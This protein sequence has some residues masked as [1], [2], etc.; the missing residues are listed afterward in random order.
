MTAE[1]YTALDAGHI[2]G[3]GENTFTFTMPDYPVSVDVEF[4]DIPTIY[5]TYDFQT[6]AMDTNNITEN[7]DATI[8]LDNGGVMTGEYTGDK[9]VSGKKMTLN[10]AFSITGN[11]VTSWVLSKNSSEDKAGLKLGR[12]TS[13]NAT[14]TINGLKVGDW[15]VIEGSEDKLG[16]VGNNNYVC[17]AGTTTTITNSSILK[18]STIYLVKEG[19]T[20]PVSI[21]LYNGVSGKSGD[22]FIYSIK[23][24]KDDNVPAPTISVDGGKVEI[25]GS[26]LKGNP[27]TIYYTIDGTDPTTSETRQTYTTSFVPTETVMVRAYAVLTSN[28]T[29]S[30]VE[31]TQKI[32]RV[33]TWTGEKNVFDF[34]SAADNLIDI[35]F[36]EVLS[37]IKMYGSSTDQ[38]ASA[39]FYPITNTDWMTATSGNTAVVA[40]RNGTGNA[41][42]ENGGLVAKSQKYF[43]I[44]NL[45]ENQRVKIEFNGQIRYR[46][47]VA[48]NAPVVQD[49]N[50]QTVAVETKFGASN[51][52]T[53]TTA[54]FTIK[55][56]SYMVFMC[57]STDVPIKKISVLPALEYVTL[58]KEASP[59]GA[60]TIEVT[61]GGAED[62]TEFVKDSE[63]TLKANPAVGYTFSRWTDGDNNA[64]TA[65]SDNTLTVTM[66]AAKTVKAVFEPWP[67]P[68]N[69]IKL[70]F[71]GHGSDNLTIGEKTKLSNIDFYYITPF[72]NVLTPY[73]FFLIQPGSAINNGAT[74]YAFSNANGLRIT[75][76]RIALDNLKSGDK[77]KINLALN[78]TAEDALVVTN[79]T[80][81]ANNMLYKQGSSLEQIALNSTINSGEEFIIGKDGH[82]VFKISNKVIITSIE[83]KTS[84]TQTSED[85]NNLVFKEEDGKLAIE[86]LGEKGSIT[87]I[88][89]TTNGAEPTK[90]S[91]K[92]E[93]PFDVD[94]TNGD[95]TVKAIAYIDYLTNTPK[96]GTYVVNQPTMITLDVAAQPTDG[97]T[98]TKA[99]DTALPTTFAKD[100]KISLK[101][102]PAEGY[103]F[104][105]WRDANGHISTLNEGKFTV[106]EGMGLKAVFKKPTTPAQE[107]T[108]AKTWTFDSFDDGTVLQFTDNAVY[109]HDGLYISGTGTKTPAKITK[110]TSAITTGI[111]DDVYSYL[112][113]GGG[114][115]GALDA[116][117]TV[118]A[119]T[120]NTIAL[121]AGVT[122]VIYAYMKG[123]YAA[124]RNYNIYTNGK[125]E[126]VAMTDGN[127]TVVVQGVRKGSVF[128]SCDGAST[129]YALKFVPET[130]SK[131]TVNVTGKGLVTVTG[132]KTSS[133]SATDADNVD[134]KTIYTTDGSEPSATNGKDYTEAFNS[135]SCTLKV[136]NVNMKTGNISEVVTQQVVIQIDA[137]T[138]VPVILVAGQSNTDGRIAVSETAFPYTL[139][140]TLMSYCNGVDY[141]QEG[142]FTAY[143][144]TPKSDSG[145]RWGYDAII[146]HKIQE[147]LGEQDYYV[148]KQ[149]KGNTAINTMCAGNNEHWWS[150][151]PVWL[152]RNISANKGGRSLLKGFLD[153]IDQSLKVLETAGKEYDIKFLMW[154]QGEADRGKGG[155]YEAQLKAVI[156]E[157]RN[158]LVT[159]TG[160]NKYSNLPV[161]LGGIAVGVSNESNATVEEGKQNLAAA[162][163]NIYYAPTGEMTLETDFRSDKVHFNATGAGKLADTVWNI[164]TT[165]DLMK[166]LTIAGTNEPAAN[167]LEEEVVSETKAWTFDASTKITAHQSINGLYPHGGSVKKRTY[168]ETTL[169]DGTLIDGVYAAETSAADR[170]GSLTEGYT[171]GYSGLTNVH[172]VNADCEG[173]FIAL[174]MPQKT[175]ADYTTEQYARLMFN[176][177]ELQA[178]PVASK[179][180]IQL[181]GKSTG[182]GTFA[183]TS[184]ASW[185]LVAAKFIA[186]KTEIE[187]VTAPT[188]EEGER[189][190][191]VRIIPGT[192]DNKTATP[193]TY[194]T[195]DGSLPSASSTP[196]TEGTDIVLT[197]DC[198]VRAI[199]I[200][201]GGQAYSATYSFKYEAP[202][203]PIL[204]D[205]KKAYANDATVTPAFATD[206]TIVRTYK[207]EA[208][209]SNGW[210]YYK[211][212]NNTT[213]LPIS[214]WLS[215]REKAAEINAEGIKATSGDRPFAIHDLKKGDVIQIEFAGNIYFATAEGFGD[216]LKGLK[217]GDAI[218][219]CQQYTVSSV[220]AASNYVVFYP[221]KAT[222]IAQISINKE[223]TPYVMVDFYISPDGN[224]ANNGSKSAPLKT[225]KKAQEIIDSGQTIH[226]LPGTYKV[227]NEE[228]MDQTNATWNVVYNLNKDNVQYI[229]ETDES[230]Q[231]PVF[232]FSG[233][234]AVGGKRITGFLLSAKKT[235]IRDIE[236]IGLNVP[237]VSGGTQS[238]FFRLNGANGS[239][240]TNI[241]AHDG[242]GIGFYIHGKSRDNLLQDCDAYDNADYTNGNGENNDGF[243]VHVSAGYTGNKLLRCRAWNNADD[244]FDLKDCRAVVT[245]EECIAYGNGKVTRNGQTITGN[246]EGI[247]GGGFGKGAFD[248]DME[249]PM[250]VVKNS[251]A[252]QNRSDGFY[253]NHHLG[254]IQLEGN[255]AYKNGT[256]FN[257]VNRD[258]ASITET[259]ETVK[260]ER[261]QV[262]GYGHLITNNIAYGN[263]DITKIVSM[264]DSEKSTVIGNSFSYADGAWTNE[265]YTDDDFVSVDP[266]V[267][268][269]A[270]NADGTLPAAVFNFLKL[271]NAATVVADPTISFKEEQQGKSIYSVTYQNGATLYYQLPGDE[272]F[273][274][275]T[276]GT[277]ADGNKVVDI[278]VTTSG[279]M[280]FYAKVGSKMSGAVKGMVYALPKLP[281]VKD[282]D[283]GVSVTIQTNLDEADKEVVDT[284]YI[285]NTDRGK[286]WNGDP[287]SVVPG[288]KISAYNLNTV[289]GVKSDTCDVYTIPTPTVTTPTVEQNDEQ[290]TDT[291]KV[292]TITFAE[293][294]KLCYLRPGDEKT[295]SSSYSDKN[296]GAIDVTASRNGVLTVWAERTVNK[297]VYSSDTLTID[298]SGIVAKPKVALNRIDGNNSIYTITFLEGTT[299]GF[300][301]PG[302]EEGSVSEGSTVD[303]TISQ[304]GRLKAWT[305]AGEA[306]SDTLNT[307]VY[308]PTPSAVSG[309]GFDFSLVSTMGAD[310]TMTFDGTVTAAGKT[311]LT[312]SEMTARTFADKLAFTNHNTTWSLLRS[313]RLRGKVGDGGV[314]DTL[315]IRNVTSGQNIA[316]TFSNN[317]TT[318]T[319]INAEGA[320]RLEAGAS[321]I[322][323][324][325]YYTITVSGDLLLQLP[326]DAGNYDILKIEFAGAETVDAPT[327]LKKQGTENTVIIRR[328][329]SSLGYDA[330]TYY[331]TDGS[332]PS[333]SSASFTKD[334]MELTINKSGVIKAFT[335][336]SSGLQSSITTFTL[337]LPEPDASDAKAIS[338]A[339]IVSSGEQL[340]F[341]ED[342]LTIYVSEESDGTWNDKKRTDFVDITTLD[343]KVAVRNG[344]TTVA[345]GAIRFTKAFAIKDLAVGDEIIIRYSGGGKL[346]VA[347]PEMGDVVTVGGSEATHGTEVPAGAVIRVTE[348]SFTDNYVVL[349]PSGKCVISGIF[350]NHPEVETLTPPAIALKNDTILNVVRLRVG[351]S[352]MGNSVSLRYTTDG[353]KPTATE[354]QE[355]SKSPLDLTIDVDCL[356]RA[357]T[358]SSS[359][360][361]SDEATFQVTLPSADRSEPE[362]YDL[363]E[364]MNETGALAF[365]SVKVA[366][367]NSEYNKET[368]SWETKRRTDF[369][370]LIS[371]DGKVSIRGGESGVTLSD[372]KIRLTRAMAIHNLGVG[373]E[374]IIDYSGD[375]TLLSAFCDEHDEYTIDGATA[376]AGME[377][378]SDGVIRV[379]VSKYENNYLVLVPSGKVFIANIYINKPAPYKVPVP[380]ISLSRVEGE[381]AVYTI[382][383]E[384]GSLLYYRLTARDRTFKGTTDGQYE[385]SID[386]SDIISL[387]ATRDNLVSDTLTTTI[388]APTPAPDVDGVTDFAEASDDL[389]MDMEVTLDEQKELEVD[390]VRLYK[391]GVLTAATFD[392]RFA[393]SETNIDNKI[394]IRTNR[395]L[396]FNKGDD[397]QMALLNLKQG[398]II[399]FD[400]TGRIE[401]ANMNHV[402][403]AQTARQR[404]RAL[405]T[406]MAD[407]LLVSGEAYQVTD[408]C[409]LLLNLRLTKEMVSIG[410]I[411]ITRPALPSVPATIDFAAAFDDYEI[412]SLGHAASVYYGG[413][414]SSQKFE[415]L[416][417]DCRRLP[418]DGK[419]STEGGSGE[420]TIDGIKAGNRR[421]AIHDLAVGD[422]I[423]IRFHGGAVTFAGHETWGN[424]ARIGN[425][426]LAD[427]D[428]LTTGDVIV[429]DKV[430]YLNNYI[431]LKLDSKVSISGLYINQAETE[432]VWAPTISDNGKN[433]I[434]ITAGRSSVGNKVTTC[435]TTDGTEPTE[436]N[437]TSG[438]YDS[439]DVEFLGGKMMQVK[440]VSYT[441]AGAVSEVV[442]M[443]IYADE[444]L[445]I[446]DAPL[447]EEQ[448]R[449]NSEAIYDLNGRR[450]QQM[451][452]GQIYIINGKKIFFR[453]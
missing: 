345:D 113:I 58:T 412:L 401:F 197:A 221:T 43:T 442:S 117:R 263:T 427:N 337:T 73:G 288:D 424:L 272:A 265:S 147:Q 48:D 330:T 346:L 81:E 114:Q 18:P 19:A 165:N 163:A 187:V 410:K 369:V 156:A 452:R 6:W 109:E 195:T 226:I 386:K 9:V 388:F 343:N 211:L 296:N 350:I 258:L 422:S 399:A 136:A 185:D 383:H 408:D 142:N 173:T 436:D 213:E 450:V 418:V 331:T 309:N 153:N 46:T 341:S 83:I 34:A 372:G 376:T 441:K 228:Y 208:S 392:D 280:L 203:P 407:S 90:S 196:Y 239:Q 76:D 24:S 305:N 16:F 241:A 175:S 306:V 298:V 85:I 295:N 304:S 278:P 188:I 174:L 283:A 36:G 417:N 128:I 382:T 82:A 227:T 3:T 166:G 79:I 27:V 215:W 49:E 110:G 183:V 384:V 78:S 319:A 342:K 182:K 120:K 204:F 307:N 250:H 168:T 47:N 77:V 270:R 256:D 344:G 445:D 145:E 324:G 329:Y 23:I 80:P 446:E 138:G 217:P 237:A 284:Y 387:W 276:E 2:T 207:D 152:S 312:P 32:F 359:G 181:I 66:G 291:K 321:T 12:T 238:E 316:I 262:A 365:D 251:I 134:I 358:V 275:T 190:N 433:T 289:T 26:S 415:R 206:K 14:F 148:I 271:K 429:I 10:G 351:T 260:D 246:G 277:I 362:D 294:T 443:I 233:V 347:T 303:V 430:D 352:S 186:G 325:T 292:Y 431:V 322:S 64:L 37:G 338:L 111:S 11:N 406:G 160:N 249:I 398:D 50:G 194:Y 69:E 89:Y 143:G 308:A 13:S 349:M 42:F 7:S 332:T 39:N 172:S 252:A 286:K 269:M 314:V 209:P 440:A 96:T 390:G 297:V 375:G 225:L 155:E 264:L 281:Q 333:L 413:K 353:S 193:A 98:L 326:A 257:M 451:K 449:K 397:M 242:N 340:S 72:K 167:P 41:A 243:G 285:K 302:G 385:L 159:R 374:I 116:S 444:L 30:S 232:D 1:P 282:V 201:E 245:I 144:T 133:L 123:G 35:T 20:E 105:E 361:V 102:V 33:G 368:D 323:S 141:T 38:D 169:A 439:F 315:V 416:T 161:I 74:T 366:V 176:G 391:P 29:I 205:F 274:S 290:S 28:N 400:Y 4:E 357:V 339:A 409:D 432:R 216:G 310:V 61:A 124:G 202:T 437:G 103:Q 140:H 355:A 191:S 146:Y 248:A 5:G 404:S 17:E 184:G 300:M 254:G 88:Y 15:F 328:G 40:W 60:G 223:L 348:T 447:Y 371:L 259:I 170:K 255:R 389:P 199:T 222:T 44:A 301:L 157:V 327:I 86:T 129:F 405:K 179:D 125:M 230:G 379:T 54:T 121:N 150:A 360:A 434:V 414:S 22:A 253:A 367:Y 299:L 71:A 99:D 21:K 236:T 419:L 25:T 279:E 122:G 192:S 94:A 380:K 320:A 112:Y 212:T 244:G 218:N 100:G 126:T 396:A 198:Q 177:E 373:D 51:A 8:V 132:S 336:S 139:N 106:T 162:D 180:Y 273:T 53:T 56:G 68:T 57:E 178:V 107:I 154:H 426:T 425:K 189:A 428:T 135:S 164:I 200:T 363:E 224:D 87:T 220:T 171:A 219:N 130:I 231:R 335:V 92:Y 403:Q 158:Y 235:V 118:D 266:A 101:A 247:K 317:N 394:R 453:N 84:T 52:A 420:I 93:A 210:T 293:G 334:E 268:T 115:N 411:V 395:H 421:M 261:M 435:Y 119:Y 97:G 354:G 370:P 287:F 63:I 378:P 402:S 311:M 229:G 95:I 108:E 214:G 356:I 149:S 91:A 62:A 423:K 234:T 70:N 377:I 318:L 131:P 31:A 55:S 75:T 240:L 104:V 313:G 151:N 127:P 137:S 59:S 65:N 45:T 364:K 381:K 267:L 438:A 393:F 448:A 67:E